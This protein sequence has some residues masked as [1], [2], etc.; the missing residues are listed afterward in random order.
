MKLKKLQK[1]MTTI[2][3]GSDGGVGSLEDEKGTADQ[4][5]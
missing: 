5:L 3:E 4:Y 1:N 2:I